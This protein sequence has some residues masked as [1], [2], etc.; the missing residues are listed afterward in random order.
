MKR[1]WKL[2]PAQKDEIAALYGDPA[3]KVDWIAVAFDITNG[4]VVA[5]SRSRGF[6]PRRAPRPRKAAHAS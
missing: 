3:N 5:I 6:P 2:S 1:T 4:A